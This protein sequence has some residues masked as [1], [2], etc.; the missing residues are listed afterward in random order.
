[1]AVAPSCRSVAA[2]EPA[3]LV[4]GDE[5]DPHGGGEHPGGHADIEDPATAVGEHPMEGAVTHDPLEGVSV[6]EWPV[7]ASAFPGG[8]IHQHV[9]MRAVPAAG[10]GVL[11]VE[12]EL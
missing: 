11:V 7:D 10:L 12:E 4:A 6:E 1:M 5:R 9:D 3:V 8:E 2:R